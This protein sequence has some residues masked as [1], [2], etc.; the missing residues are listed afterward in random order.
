MDFKYKPSDYN[1][2]SPY[3]VVN[4]AQE[5]IDLMMNCSMEKSLGVT[6][7]QDELCMLKY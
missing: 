6:K 2:L 7:F 3:L 4:G 1:S 5:L